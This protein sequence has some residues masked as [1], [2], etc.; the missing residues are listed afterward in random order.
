M[1]KIIIKNIKKIVKVVE[2]WW[3]LSKMLSKWLKIQQKSLKNFYQTIKKL[4]K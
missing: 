2:I 4:W 3:K 1:D